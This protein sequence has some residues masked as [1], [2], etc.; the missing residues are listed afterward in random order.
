MEARI[1]GEKNDKMTKKKS[2]RQGGE[3]QQPDTLKRE[4]MTPL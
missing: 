4:L 2:K 3:V 1:I